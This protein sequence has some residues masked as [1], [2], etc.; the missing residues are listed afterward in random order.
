MEY[1]R[2]KR[3]A[4][5]GAGKA[6]P[7]PMAGSRFRAFGARKEMWIYPLD[8]LWY[9]FKDLFFGGNCHAVRQKA[10]H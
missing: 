10:Y 2:T 8:E 5:K 9:N 3:N 4:D 1:I 7:R 6:G